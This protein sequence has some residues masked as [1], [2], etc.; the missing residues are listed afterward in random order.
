MFETSYYPPGA[1]YFSVNVIGAL[2]VAS[3][4]TNIDNSFEDVSG[5]TAAFDVEE[6]AEGGENRFKHRLPTQA[7]YSNLVLKR[8]IV[9]IDSFLAEWCGE[10][11][12]SSLSTPILPQNI[13]VT[14]LNESGIP[15]IAWGFSNAWPVKWEISNMNAQENKIL[16]ETLEFSYNYFERVNLTGVG[17]ATKIA[18]LI[19]KL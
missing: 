17:A 19:S 2:G 14:L 18:K 12:G 11:I 16:T 5:I 1:F 6:I 8:G 3:L 13:L 15:T 9:T 10:T 7:I 4:V